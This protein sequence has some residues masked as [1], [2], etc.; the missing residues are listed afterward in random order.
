MK[1]TIRRCYLRCRRLFG[2][3]RHRVEVCF[4]ALRDFV[5]DGGRF[6]EKSWRKFCSTLRVVLV[7]LPLALVVLGVVFG[8]DLLLWGERLWDSKQDGVHHLRPSL[9]TAG[10]GLLAALVAAGFFA[11]RNITADERLENAQLSLQQE[12]YQ[13]GV[14]LL[15]HKSQVVRIGGLYALHQLAESFPRTWA[16]P[17]MELMCAFVRT[18]PL[19]K[20]KAEG[21]EE[22][23]LRRD[24]QE[25]VQLLGLRGRAR[26]REEKREQKKTKKKGI[27]NSPGGGRLDFHG[28]DLAGGLWRGV[29]LEGADFFEAT[30][31]GANFEGAKLTEAYFSEAKLEKANFWK[32]TLTGAYFRETKLGGAN[33]SFAKLTG[34]Y[35]GKA[36]LGGAD[37]SEAKLGGAFFEGA[38][39]ATDKLEIVNFSWATLT[40]ANFKKALLEKAFF[41][42]A[43][44]NDACFDGAT[45]TDAN[46][47]VATLT[48]A[49]F[50]EATIAGANLTRANL[51]GAIL[52]AHKTIMGKAISELVK[53]VTRRQLEMGW[54]EPGRPPVK[55]EEEDNMQTMWPTRTPPVTL[56][57]ADWKEIGLDSP[58]NLREGPPP[59]WPF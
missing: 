25:A 52:L 26:L 34:A 37:F 45:L 49:D 13:K 53:G 1:E 36:K 46:F 3:S 15:G 7:L 48:G 40:K 43:T 41:Y 56:T 50:S 5:D 4:T 44:L 22:K 24:V 55:I 10:A 32:A 31:T 18:P 28:A 59:G 9:I 21:S 19:D 6:F 8:P 16:L 14:E 33:F 27:G 29:D 57:E 2:E 38:T 42:G 54:F 17:V 12:R 51:S 58:P 30:L 47:E 20:D 23:W 39:V 35:F 11:W